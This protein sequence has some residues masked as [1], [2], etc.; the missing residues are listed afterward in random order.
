MAEIY[1][2]HLIHQ[3]SRKH[4]GRQTMESETARDLVERLRKTPLYYGY[5][6]ATDLPEQAA[7]AI[8]HL[9]RER[10][11]AQRGY[12]NTKLWWETERQNARKHEGTIAGMQTQIDELEAAEALSERLTQERDD[13]LE[14]WQNAVKGKAHWYQKCTSLLAERDA[15][16][17]R[18]DAAERS[19]DEMRVERDALR[20]KAEVSTHMLAD[21]EGAL[22]TAREALKPFAQQADF[23][24]ERDSDFRQIAVNLAWFRKARAALAAL[25]KV[26]ETGS[27]GDGWSWQWSEEKQTFVQQNAPETK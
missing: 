8:E 23:A 25:P 2:T 5:G 27:K 6:E 1:T 22:A 16:I 26:P 9:T 20:V 13:A 11:D 15:A 12:L 7:D 21:A 17:A 10:D 19:K 14:D 3:Q 18:A 24:D 4:L